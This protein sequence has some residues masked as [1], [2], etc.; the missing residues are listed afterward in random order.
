MI[1]SIENGRIYWLIFPQ[2]N[3][4]ALKQNI[5]ETLTLHR[6]NIICCK[7]HSRSIKF[8]MVTNDSHSIP[9]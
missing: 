1:S 5:D 6:G 7:A 4:I 3:C 8:S 2:K 9:K